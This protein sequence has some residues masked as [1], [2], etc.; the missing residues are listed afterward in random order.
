MT[1]TINSMLYWN[2][3][4]STDWEACQGREQSRFFAQLAIDE[5]PAWFKRVVASEN[6]TICD[7]GCAEADGTEVL[8]SFF[9]YDKV[10]GVDFS[11]IAIHRARELYHNLELRVEDWLSEKTE[12]NGK[13]YDVVFSSNTLE[14]FYQPY[15]ILKTIA[16]F[17]NKL[18]VLVLPYRELERIAEHHY[19]FLPENIPLLADGSLM[20]VHA[21]AIDSAKLSPTYWLGQQIVLIYA[22]KEWV[23]SRALSL[24]D[25][26]LQA[27]TD[28]NKEQI[29]MLSETLVERDKQIARLGQAIDERE[30]QITGLGEVL[31]ERDRQISSLNQLLSE[32]IGEIE[33]LKT[34][35]SWL[36]TRPLRF[37]KK[38]INNPRRT[39]YD[40]LKFVYWHL[41][42][43][44]RQ[45][46]H[47]LRT[48]IVRQA[49]NGTFE[50]DPKVISSMLQAIAANKDKPVIVFR[51]LIDWYIPLF[52][53]PQH[54]AQQLARLG[55]NYFYCVHRV[56][57]EENIKFLQIEKN[58]Y[59]TNQ[60][61][62]A[63]EMPNMIL[64]VYAHD[65][66]LGIN[67]IKH[68][69]SKGCLIIYEYIDE[70]HPDL[71]GMVI[72]KHVWERHEYALKTEEII[73][74]CSAEKLLR[75]AHA[76]R[77]KNVLYVT[78]GVEVD[79]FT[80]VQRTA[81]PS[82]IA[83]FVDAGAPV[84]GY[85][86][87]LAKWFDYELIVRLSTERPQY[88]ILLIGWD[89][90]Q[91]LSKY[92]LEDFKN[93]KFIGPVDYKELPYFAAWFDVSIIPFIV[94]AVTQSTSPIKLF[95][96]MALGKPIVTTD[97]PE[98]RLYK[99][100]LVA[101]DHADFILKID[102][103]L[104]LGTEADYIE[105]LRKEAK[106]NSW[107]SK[108]EAISELVHS[109]LGKHKNPIFGDNHTQF[110]Q[111]A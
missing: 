72:P 88:N 3:R 101:K 75:E 57:N 84:I 106:E 109:N 89:F 44:A 100:P 40:S 83:G 71:A 86:G 79:H 87:A 61:A 35:T 68:F 55:F 91:S 104:S 69:Q 50:K 14:H 24:G 20:L 56:F 19:T 111:N 65:M 30:E 107:Y 21:T 26:E 22:R 74:I 94:N 47:G 51:P 10:T 38:F 4:F 58:L 63:A 77:K 92:R 52:Q 41:P 60:Y 54:L 1:K 90:D 102:H 66:T 105:A 46:F 45:R 33:A 70:I 108:A 32:K 96:Y 23:Q 42:P 36:V 64:H 11:E 34:S 18:V 5:L 9:G 13:N 81:P 93:I 15:E 98:C 39:S 2:D 48:S 95:E 80:C 97:M 31:V 62:S 28:N 12:P 103:A 99:S 43:F 27:V 37:L 110:A 85:F 25:I 59:L 7:W 78:N 67:E 6:M 29:D 8:A 76:Y 49:M 53:R 16:R 82:Q 17:A 73:V